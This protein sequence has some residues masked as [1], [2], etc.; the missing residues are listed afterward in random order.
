MKVCIVSSYFYPVNNV[1]SNRVNAI[2]Q[3]LSELGVDVDVYVR[4][5]NANFLN[6]F[7]LVNVINVS[8]FEMPPVSFDCSSGIKHKF[9]VVKKI[10]CREFNKRTNFW[11]KKVI[12]II[13][14]KSDGYDY[15]IASF[16]EIETLICADQ[17]CS[18]S[19]IR[20]LL[21]FRDGFIDG[22]KLDEADYSKRVELA[23]RLEAKNAVVTTVSA[24]LVEQLNKH[25]SDVYEVR[26]GF[27]Y[28]AKKIDHIKSEYLRMAFFGSFYGDIRPDAFFS[29]LDRFIANNVKYKNA[30]KVDFFGTGKTFEVPEALV[31]IAAFHPKL[32]YD[33]AID[34]M[35]SYD[36]LLLILPNNGKKGIFSGKLFD[37]IG[38]YSR[39]FAIVDPNDVAAELIHDNGLGW[40]ADHNDIPE[41]ESKIDEIVK[42]YVSSGMIVK[43]NIDVSSFHRRVGV[44]KLLCIMESKLRDTIE[45]E[46]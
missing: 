13:C 10:F 12:G 39:I 4:N 38:S 14:S 27:D 40:V 41:I 28:E 7:P 18:R 11:V 26:N 35:K 15:I 5:S 2:A 31:S 45:V 16:P 32:S 22:I 6:R 17:V 42:E 29:A 8:A 37:Y 3:Y 34:K 19:N 44:K 9:R 25:F 20:P 21:D 1:A 30:I 36:V 46:R 23:R 33:E 43:N 24:P